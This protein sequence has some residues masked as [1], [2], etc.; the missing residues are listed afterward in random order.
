MRDKRLRY[1]WPTVM[2]ATTARAYLDDVVSA[3]QFEHLVAPHLDGRKIAGTLVFTRRSIDEWLE[4]DGRAS[5]PT[6]P[7]QLARLLDNDDNTD[8]KG[9]ELQK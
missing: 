9:Q 6:T 5:A 8:S 4:H 3:A 7:E 2:Q 1:E